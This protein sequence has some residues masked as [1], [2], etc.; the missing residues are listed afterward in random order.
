MQATDSVGHIEVEY[1]HPHVL[2]PGMQ[3]ARVDPQVGGVAM[4]PFL[5]VDCFAM[6]QPHFPPHPHAGFSAVTYLL[7]HSAGSVL[8]RDSRGEAVV[9]LPGGLHW[10]EAAAG[11][12][13]EETP[14]QPGV[15]CEGLQVFVN[16]PAAQRLAA[17]A[18][19]HAD[20][21]AFPVLSLEGGSLR[22]LVGH[23]RGHSAPVVPRTACCWLDMEIL[24]DASLGLDIPAG[25]SRFALL[26]RGS[27]RG[28]DLVCSGTERALVRLPDAASVLVRAGAEGAMAP[29]PTAETVLARLER[30]VS[31]IA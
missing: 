6:A 21:S 13:H 15:V 26:V 12:M 2:G 19:Y 20:A 29:I 1:L 14:L 31:V 3:V 30:G 7:R 23:Y 22:V 5:L 4:D 17:P 9:I 24:P 8:N 16:L 25:W 28:S 18:V 10:T 27:L 11:M